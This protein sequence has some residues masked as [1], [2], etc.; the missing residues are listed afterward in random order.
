M[1][2]KLKIGMTCY[3]TLG[4]SGV[5]ATELGKLMAEKGHQ[6]HFITHSMPFRLLGDYQKN[7]YYHEVEVSDYAV[8]RYPPYDLSLASK[9]AQVVQMQQLDLL[10]VHYALPHAICAF[11]A[12]QIV[13]EQ[14]KVVT[15]LHG[16]D[17]TVLAQE[18]SLRDIIRLAIHESD[19]VTAVSNSLI[20]ETRRL[21]DIERPIDLTYNFIDTREYYPRNCS[22]LRAEYAEPHERILIHISNFRPV[23]RAM[24]VVDIFRRVNEQVPAKILFVGEGPDLPKVHA[25]LKQLGLLDRVYFLGKQGDVSQVLS[26]ADLLFLPSEK[27][28]FGLVALEAM[29][30]GV[31]TIASNTGGVPELVSDGETGYLCDVGDTE[32]M[33]HMAL[34]LLQDEALYTAFSEACQVR[35]REQFGGARHAARY[36]E[37]YYRVLEREV[38]IKDE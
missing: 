2:D 26:I 36:E 27:E 15:T 8:F 7:I 14:L 3:P 32:K 1:K 22:D 17:I 33:A 25:A 35:A 28:S 16:T 34:R 6:V 21:L 4:G 24:D 31:P 29:A 9:M 18:E 5:V 38:S 20:E 30:C 19:A 10:H 37:I 23:K 12:K 11:L 13:G